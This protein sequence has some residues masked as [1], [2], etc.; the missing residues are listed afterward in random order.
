MSQIQPNLC[1]KF[2]PNVI[3]TLQRF[4][5]DFHLTPK[6]RLNQL[7]AKLKLPF[8]IQLFA[9][10]HQRHSAPLSK[11]R[12]QFCLFDNQFKKFALGLLLSFFCWHVSLE[13]SHLNFV[14]RLCT[15]SCKLYNISHVPGNWITDLENWKMRSTCWGIITR[16]AVLYKLR[17]LY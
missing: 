3:K 10:I 11:H 6:P 17:Y 15:L 8:Q 2:W 13:W 9:N 14:C 7:W 1:S 12:N 16:V 5:I 4:L